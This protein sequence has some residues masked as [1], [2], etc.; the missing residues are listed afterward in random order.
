MVRTGEK[1]QENMSQ[2]IKLI[3]YDC[4]GVL[5]DSKGANKAFYNHI[6][7]HFNMPLMNDEQLNFVHSSSAREAI[8]LL[9][10][11]TPLVEEAQ[12]YRHQLDYS[13][14]IPLMKP[15]PFLK[16]VLRKLH[17]NYHTAIATNRGHTT[18]VLLQNHQ[19]QELFDL[20]V[21]SMDVTQSKP[22]P[23]GILKVLNY[24]QMSPDEALYIG[25]SV[26][27]E[28]VCQ[29]AGVSFAA[30]K[31]SCLKAEYHLNNHR[32]LLNLLGITRAK[33]S[34]N[35]KTEQDKIPVER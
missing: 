2:K 32:G 14:F 27:D 11:A 23:E 15:E 10:R 33:V 25:D 4:D 8:N 19:L 34:H 31:N 16:E 1:K 18:P 24:F 20:V 17:P 12:D 30:Y 21:T 9:F 13:Q 6:L 28:E 29:R 7:E 26:V 35:K 3:I 5:F 22:H